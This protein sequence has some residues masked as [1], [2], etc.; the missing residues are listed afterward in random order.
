MK[1]AVSLIALVLVVALAFTACSP[2]PRQV[3][4]D[5]MALI[6]KIQTLMISASSVLEP[7]PMENGYGYKFSGEYKA[8]NGDV[9]KYASYEATYGEGT[10]SM[11]QEVK[12][13]IDGKEHSY[14]FQMSGTETDYDYELKL[15]GTPIVIDIN[16]IPSL[17]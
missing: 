5:D 10:V 3:T 17:A 7:V 16:D 4:E 15:D 1:K 12:A 11:S 14:T 13:I 2:A 6:E 8:P 9:L